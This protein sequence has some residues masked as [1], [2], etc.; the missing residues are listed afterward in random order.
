MCIRDSANA[1]Q[2][3]N[4]GGSI[5]C[6]VSGTGTTTTL[7]LFECSDTNIQIPNGAVGA[8]VLVNMNGVGSAQSVNPP[9][10]RL[11]Q[12]SYTVTVNVP[13]GYSNTGGTI[14]CDLS[15]TCT[16]TTTTTADPCLTCNDNLY[17]DVDMYTKGSGAG[18]ANGVLVAWK[19][20]SD[21][22]LFGSSNVNLHYSATLNGSYTNLGSPKL[23]NYNETY[24]PPTEQ[25]QIGGD[26]DPSYI[27]EVNSAGL[28]D[29]YYYITAIESQ[30][31]C[32]I[33]SPTVHMA[34]E[35]TTAES[36]NKYMYLWGVDCSGDASESTNW[37]TASTTVRGHVLM[38]NP[39]TTLGTGNPNI[40]SQ[41]S[42]TNNS[43]VGGMVAGD[44]FNYSVPHTGIT[45]QYWGCTDINVLR[46]K[47]DLNT[48]A[49]RAAFDSIGTGTAYQYTGTSL[50][51]NSELDGKIK[52]CGIAIPPRQYPIFGS[53]VFHRT[54]TWNY[55][56]GKAFRFPGTLHM[57][58][59]DQPQSTGVSAP[60]DGTSEQIKE[61]NHTANPA[62]TSQDWAICHGLT[63]DCGFL[64]PEDPKG[65]TPTPGPSPSP[66][67]GGGDNEL[68]EPGEEGIE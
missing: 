29:G 60:H 24:A 19:G 63:A 16:T 36:S 33:T 41:Y 38:V 57:V 51:H 32:T 30:T 34:V 5:V 22:C 21:Q 52:F 40:A 3:D 23:Y 53:L 58:N 65:V 64:E 7:P 12:H 59:S 25:T 10:Y 66:G 8:N 31:G 28:D 61:N 68:S 17:L 55:N 13:A 39:G 37:Y 54:D 15:G 47:V 48:S 6:L 44:G 20:G 2:Y 27:Y 67:G 45:K 14:P 56:N 9:T 50:S 4:A 26:Q 42:F 49:G 18:V 11:G 62:S 1:T 43:G 46:I 35:N